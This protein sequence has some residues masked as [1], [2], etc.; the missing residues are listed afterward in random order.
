MAAKRK[1]NKG[2]QCLRYEP[3]DMNLINEDPTIVEIFRRTGCLQFCERLQGC[4]VKV[5]KEFALNFSGTTTKVG[6]L[7]LNITPE[8]IAAA[9]WIPR[10]QEKW[11]KGFKFNME[12]CKEFIKLESSEIDLTNAIPRSGMKDNFSKLLLIIQKY[13]TCEGRYHKVYSYHFKLLLHFAS[14]ISLD[15]P[16]YLHRSLAKMANKIQAKS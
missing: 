1:T 6:I 2:G 11:F 13:F 4:H 10:G 16:F 14:K 7:N 12:E 5:S 15:L 9:T 3:S 8:I